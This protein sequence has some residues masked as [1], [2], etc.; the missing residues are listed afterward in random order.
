MSKVFK[1]DKGKIVFE[2]D[3]II[4]SDDAKTKRN[5]F[6]FLSIIW[7]VCGSLNILRYFDDGEEYLLWTSL[8]T[9]PLSFYILLLMILRSTKSKIPLNEIKSLKTGKVF[10]DEYLDIKLKSKRTRRVSRLKN[11]EEVDTY[12]KT[13]SVL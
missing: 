10:S 12:I 3:M 8:V 13:N 1:T 2:A 11:R 5:V 7:I 6:L 4:V 9:V